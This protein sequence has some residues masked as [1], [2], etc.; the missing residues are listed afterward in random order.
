MGTII[1]NGNKPKKDD[2]KTAQNGTFDPQIEEQQDPSFG[3]D[4]TN[5]PNVGVDGVDFYQELRSVFANCG[6]PLARL[7]L[8]SN[9]FAFSKQSTNSSTMASLTF[10]RTGDVLNGSL[11]STDGNLDLGEH[12]V[13]NEANYKLQS[14][15]ISAEPNN[16]FQLNIFTCSSVR[17]LSSEQIDGK[18]YDVFEVTVSEVSQEDYVVRWFMNPSDANSLDQIHVYRKSNGVNVF[19]A[20]LVRSQ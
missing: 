2:G 11:T 5:Q 17:T 8:G 16:K 9:K 20:R 10:L 12:D 15:N 3:N 4:T 1:G 7:S 18:N 14:R 13:V 6:S 19:Q